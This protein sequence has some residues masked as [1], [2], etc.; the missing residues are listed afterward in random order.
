MTY[1]FMNH[2]D[3]CIEKYFKPGEVITWKK[4]VSHDGYDFYGP[5]SNLYDLLVISKR[6][7]LLYYSIFHR[8]YWFCGIDNESFSPLSKKIYLNL[9][10][11]LEKKNY[12]QIEKFNILEN[13]LL[14]KFTNLVVK[15]ILDYLVKEKIDEKTLTLDENCKFK[16]IFLIKD[17]LG[18]FT[19]Y[20][21]N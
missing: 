11:C 20:S 7:K 5:K 10:S 9:T 18:E 17:F 1:V 3:S 14:K 6:K 2:I 12:Y 21:R 8:E 13:L 16:K 19:L 4:F 15:L